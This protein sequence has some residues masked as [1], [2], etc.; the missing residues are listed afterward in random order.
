MTVHDRG[1]REYDPLQKGH[2]SWTLVVEHKVICY[3]WNKTEI[4][5]TDRFFGTNTSSGHRYNIILAKNT[6]KVSQTCLVSEAVVV[7]RVNWWTVIS[8]RIKLCN[9]SIDRQFYSDKSLSTFILSK[10]IR[11]ASITECILIQVKTLA[12]RW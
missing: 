4:Q 12:L 8:M 2:H 11:C 3:E 9:N 10:E 6:G 7:T 5:N 1:Q